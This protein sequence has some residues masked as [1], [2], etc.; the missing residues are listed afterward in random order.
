MPAAFR[1]VIR[2]ALEIDPAKRYPAVPDL[3]DALA[4]V[5]ISLDWET[6]IDPSGLTTWRAKRKE[7]PDLVVRL[8]QASN[9]WSVRI[10]TDNAGTLRA[11]D[12]TEWA[13]SLT[14][15]QA[16]AKLKQVFHSLA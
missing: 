1:A 8:E 4:N 12:R 2:R 14:Q 5:S 6:T 7:Q 10:F 15:R 9:R 3:Q 13:S 11:K 16:A